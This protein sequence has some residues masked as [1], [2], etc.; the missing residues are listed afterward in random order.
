[1]GLTVKYFR[2]SLQHFPDDMIIVNHE[3]ED[4]VHF[5]NISDN[6]LKLSVSP[7]IGECNRCGS[8][9]HNTT[10]KG[11]DAVCTDCDENLYSF[12]Y[13]KLKDIKNK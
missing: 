10:V 9:V 3:N 4:F 13:T 12:E 5:M 8:P 2:E 6:R 1:M 7:K 11:Y